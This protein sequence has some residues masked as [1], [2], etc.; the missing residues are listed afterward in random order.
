MKKQTPVTHRIN[1]TAL[2]LLEEN[3]EGITW[4]NLNKMIEETDEQFHPKTINGCVWKLVEKFPDT[5][6]KPEKGLFRLTKYK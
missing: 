1:E 3:P 5:V 6:Y 4:S 2:R